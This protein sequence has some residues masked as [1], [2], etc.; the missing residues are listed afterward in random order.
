MYKSSVF[1]AYPCAMTTSVNT[2]T[3]FSCKAAGIGPTNLA[4]VKNGSSLP[5]RNE[6]AIEQKQ[7][8]VTSTLTIQQII[9]YDMGNYYCVATSYAGT[10]VSQSAFLNVTG[11]T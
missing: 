10:V 7:N 3:L 1:T 11:T 9:R 4:W 5:A 6:V 8:F 2:D